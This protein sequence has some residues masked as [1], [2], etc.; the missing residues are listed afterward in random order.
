MDPP[1]VGG[2]RQRA[3]G[4][5]VVRFVSWR[6]RDGH[7]HARQ[8]AGLHER[9]RDVVAVADIGE[10]DAFQV[11][12]VPAEGQQIGQGLA[13]V[14]VVGQGIDDGNA[15][16]VGELFERRLRERAYDDRGRVAR[17][18]ARGVGKRLATT[19]LQV[20]RAQHD[21]EHAE[22]VRGDLERYARARR[23]LVE[24]AGDRLAVPRG[25]PPDGPVLH[26]V[27]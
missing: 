1:C 9:V 15:R 19:E 11:A 17:Q 4:D 20:V 21:R 10:P 24:Q 23:L 7:V 2:E 26:L 22:P 18:H 16:G 27:G 12:E 5:V 8:G 13:R 14:M 25:G 3:G 6:C